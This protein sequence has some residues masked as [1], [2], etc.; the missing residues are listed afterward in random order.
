LFGEALSEDRHD[1]REQHQAS[2]S[3]S[4]QHSPSLCSNSQRFRER[5]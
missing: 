5:N 1:H 2:T 3:F 4:Q